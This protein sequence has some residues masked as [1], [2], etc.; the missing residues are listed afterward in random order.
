MD[1][2]KKENEMIVVEENFELIIWLEDGVYKSV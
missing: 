2:S 1:L